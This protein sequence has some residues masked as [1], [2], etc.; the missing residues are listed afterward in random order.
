MERVVTRQSKPSSWGWNW[1]WQ[2]CHHLSNQNTRPPLPLQSWYTIWQALQPTP[3]GG[4]LW[5]A[6]HSPSSCTQPTARVGRSSCS[7]PAGL[8][9]VLPLHLLAPR[10]VLC[11]PSP[12]CS[13]LSSSTVTKLGTLGGESS[14]HTDQGLGQV[15]GGAEV[16]CVHVEIGG[17][18]QWDCLNG[19]ETKCEGSQRNCNLRSKVHYNKGTETT[20]LDA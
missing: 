18:R 6:L 19:S 14:H 1:I 17:H 20:L 12:G 16:N 10:S 5:S 3:A 4:T 11:Q 9:C 2:T 15:E 7:W 13:H 8:H